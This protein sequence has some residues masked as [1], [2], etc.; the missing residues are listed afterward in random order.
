MRSMN[1]KKAR[2]I[3]S[4]YIDGSLPHHTRCA[5]E[6][7]ITRC[8]QCAMELDGMREM[9]S[10]LSSLSTRGCPVDCWPAIRGELAEQGRPWSGW[11]F[12][13]RPVV[14]AP[15]AA[16]AAVLAALLVMPAQ[17]Q[18]SDR[19][20]ASMMEYGHYI[21]AHAG[22]QRQQAF[23]DPDVTFVAAELEK[24]R[25]TANYDRQ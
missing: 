13:L 20:P 15:T 2:E 24:A 18:M 22:A 1:C 10:T 7:H 23:A 9:L 8:S 5:Y 14:V 11:Q 21:T 25:V 19:S 12:L 3:T 6:E 16:L 4:D 17:M